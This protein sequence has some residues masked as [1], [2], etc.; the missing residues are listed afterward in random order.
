MY[1]KYSQIDAAFVYAREH[2]RSNHLTDTYEFGI[3][4]GESLKKICSYLKNI[5]LVGSFVWGFDSF[6]GLGK[7]AP[8][9]EVFEKFS[10]GSY[11]F[12]LEENPVKYI[13]NKI[14]YKYSIIIKEWFSNL[15]N[16]SLVP[17]MLPA[18]LVHI[19]CDLFSA[20]IDALEFLFSNKIIREGTL[21]A[22]D[23]FK[24]TKGLAGE[25]RAHLVT[26]NKY[27]A[28]AEEIW[29][30]Q[31]QDKSTGQKIR[32]SVWEVLKIES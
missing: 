3:Y 17:C 8:G 13:K 2:P 7:E 24:S 5:N 21:I 23:E 15:K 4:K 10:E 32:Q 1:N 18:F 19:D 11:K 29:H 31:Y 27:M 28:E 9:M 30:Y 6:E 25:E 26:F 14:D 20:T 16:H 22:Y 12:D